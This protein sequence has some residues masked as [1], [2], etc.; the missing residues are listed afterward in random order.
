MNRGS[1]FC[2]LVPYHLAMSPNIQFM[3]YELMYT[4]HCSADQKS[5]ATL[6]F[7]ATQCTESVTRLC[8]NSF[9][10]AMSPNIQFMRC[11]VIKWSGKRGSNPRPLPW[12]GS[13]LSTELFPHLLF[14]YMTKHL[15]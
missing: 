12:Q 10:M 8:S 3:R 11:V 14:N 9:S 15:K 6:E 2:R 4:T 1:E 13:A 5:F 7:L